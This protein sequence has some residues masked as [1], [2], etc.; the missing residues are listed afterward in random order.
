MAFTIQNTIWI[1]WKADWR[2]MCYLVWQGAVP[3]PLLF[4]MFF[5]YQINCSQF[6]TSAT[7]L[8]KQI[9]IMKSNDMHA[10]NDYGHEHESKPVILFIK[11]TKSTGHGLWML[12]G[13]PP[14]ID[15]RRTYNPVNWVIGS[16]PAKY[17]RAVITRWHHSPFIFQWLIGPIW[18]SILCTKVA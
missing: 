11:P 6:S 9:S 16:P 14:D 1:T 4:I 15:R 13:L 7:P 8:F 3:W 10:Q 18:P 12:T 5:T 2:Y 17:L